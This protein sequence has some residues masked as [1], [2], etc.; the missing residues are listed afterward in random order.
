MQTLRNSLMLS[1]I[2]ASTAVLALMGTVT[3]SAPS[4]NAP[5]GGPSALR[6]NPHRFPCGSA[7]FLPRTPAGAPFMYHCHILEREDNGMM[8]QYTTLG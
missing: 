4:L 3:L 6:S 2:R 1:S 8:G 7:W 5:F